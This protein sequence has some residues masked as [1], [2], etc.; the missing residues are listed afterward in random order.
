MTMKVSVAVW[1]CLVDFEGL[2][3]L[4]AKGMQG[5]IKVTSDLRAILKDVLY[6]RDC[7]CP[8]A[9]CPLLNGA[10][11]ELLVMSWLAFAGMRTSVILDMVPSAL[12]RSPA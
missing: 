1:F 4:V 3:A 9:F 2:Q 8:S 5:E 11:K 12:R 10:A 6:F 7:G